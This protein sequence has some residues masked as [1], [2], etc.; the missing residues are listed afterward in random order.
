MTDKSPPYHAVHSSH[1]AQLCGHTRVSSISVPQVPFQIPPTTIMEY[2]KKVLQSVL[3]FSTLFDVYWH[4]NK[5]QQPLCVFIT[6]SAATTKMYLKYVT[7]QVSRH[8]L[9]GFMQITKFALLS[10][11]LGCSFLAKLL[12]FQICYGCLWFP[13]DV[14]QWLWGSPDL[15][16]CA[17]KRLTFVVLSEVSQQLLNGLPCDLC[18]LLNS[19]NYGYPLILVYKQIPAKLMT[20]P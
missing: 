11:C 3:C 16:S 1:A 12:G 2:E 6:L 10:S 17:T 18:S 4:Y 8:L 15:L 20:F 19:N 9:W 5:P 7:I 13:D 14:S